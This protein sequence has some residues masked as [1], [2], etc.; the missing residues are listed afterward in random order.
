MERYEYMRIK[1]DLIPDNFKTYY[2][3]HDKIHIGY[4]YCKIRRGMYGL[5]QAGIIANQ[6]LKKRLAEFGYFELPHTPGLWKHASRPVQFTLVVDDFGI[7]YVGQDHLNHLIKAL[8]KFYEVSVDESGSL[9]CGISL[10]WD[11]DKRILDISMP[12]YVIKQLTKYKH[13]KP[14]KPQ[15][16]PWEPNP[17]YYGKKSQEVD[18]TDT[19]P[20]LDK[21]GI[22]FIQQVCGS[23]LY[24]CRATDPTIPCALNELASLQTEATENTMKRCKQFLDY[25]WTI[26][27]AS[28]RYY[29]SDMILNVHSDASYLSVKNARSRAAGWF[30]LG[31]IPKDCQPIRLNGAVDVLCTVLK[32]VAASAAEAELGALFLNAKQAKILRLTLEEMGHPQPPTPI[33]IDNSTTVG[34]VNNT[35]ERQK[36]RGM[37]MRYFWLLDTR[38]TKQQTI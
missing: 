1:A 16:C 28:I 8:K 31:S 29:A 25:M 22:K 14:K 34:I 19:S 35:I 21:D 36:S 12:G 3:L 9:Y 4:I 18:E 32:F 13:P 26:P 15:H 5:P 11:Y 38:R 30:F 17:I 23:F 33:H 37:E 10:K 2:K 24:Y 27:D 6:L 7:K 20:P